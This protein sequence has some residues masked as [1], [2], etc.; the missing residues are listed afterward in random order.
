MSLD[1]FTVGENTGNV[2]PGLQ[3]MARQYSESID[4][5]VKAFMG[6]I[7]TGVLLFVFMFVGL[8]AFGIISAVFQLSSSLSGG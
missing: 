7:S 1:I 4:K 2:V 8:I 5:I 3:Q 6:I